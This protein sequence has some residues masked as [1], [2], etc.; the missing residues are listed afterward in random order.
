M[1]TMARGSSTRRRAVRRRPVQRSYGS[2]RLSAASS[3]GR[4]AATTHG[5][6]GDKEGGD[7]RAQERCRSPVPHLVRAQSSIPLRQRL[8]RIY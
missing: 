8:T 6:E 4:Q 3:Y 5:E 7:E 1:K 2:R